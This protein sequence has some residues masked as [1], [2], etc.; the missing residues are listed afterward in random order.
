MWEREEGRRRKEEEKLPSL[1][2][3]L[4]YELWECDAGNVAKI[5]K[6]VHL[7]HRVRNRV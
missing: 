7:Y 6:A 4:E 5:L 3:V 1:S 2:V